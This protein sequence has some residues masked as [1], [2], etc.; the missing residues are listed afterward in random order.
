MLFTIQ[1]DDQ[2]S[3]G[4]SDFLYLHRLYSFKGGYDFN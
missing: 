1:S 3:P 4:I 2:F